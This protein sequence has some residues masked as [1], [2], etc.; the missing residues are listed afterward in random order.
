MTGSSQGIQPKFRQLRLEIGLDCALRCRHCSVFAGP[1]NPRVMDEAS[2]LG[3]VDA[4]AHVGG[5]ELTIT[6]GEPLIVFDKT[7]RIIQHAKS[8]QL[9]TVVFTSGVLRGEGELAPLSTLAST[10]LAGCLDR[11]VF[12]LYSAL[13]AG[14]NSVTGVKSSYALALEAITN[15]VRA[16]LQV[17]IHFV[18][19]RNA[20][21][22]LRRLHVLGGELGVATI[23]VIRFVS[24]GRARA[25]GQLRPTSADLRDLR[26]A[27]EELASVPG[28]KIR[29][30]PAFRF[31]SDSAPY[32]TAAMQELV[33]GCDG[34]IYPCSGFIGYD[35]PEAIGNIFESGL[36]EVWERSRFLAAIRTLASGRALG[37]S[38]NRSGCPAQKAFIAGRITDDIA[39]PDAGY[40]TS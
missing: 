7:L 37:T 11:I 27:V 17:E 30:G 9:K 10:T 15:A 19:M 3:L 16:G 35:G 12:T 14:H 36:S 40:A 6:G 4:F 21:E 28:P 32:C 2:I 18:P 24:H 38:P 5:E 20:G 1:G 39:D 23:R 31:L 34:R 26:R 8:L 25:E 13:E 22:Q 29:L 33:V